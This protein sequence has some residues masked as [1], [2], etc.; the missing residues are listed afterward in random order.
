MLKSQSTASLVQATLVPRRD[1][2]STNSLTVS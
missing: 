2:I 1:S